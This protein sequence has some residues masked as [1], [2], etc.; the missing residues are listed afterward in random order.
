MDV[1]IGHVYPVDFDSAIAFRL[2]LVGAE[3]SSFG[4]QTSLLGF[5]V[6]KAL[7]VEKARTNID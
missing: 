5:V 4:R 1:L 2:V 7:I 6:L 3:E